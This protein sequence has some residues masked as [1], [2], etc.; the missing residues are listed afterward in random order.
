MTFAGA[1]VGP[2]ARFLYDG[3][4][5]EVVELYAVHGSPEALVREARSDSVR[6]IA[7][8][9]LMFSERSR[10]LTVVQL[11]LERCSRAT[12]R[13]RRSPLRPASRGPVTYLISREGFGRRRKRKSSTSDC[14]PLSAG[15]AATRR[16]AKLDY[17][18]T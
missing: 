14:E 6:R 3:E 9:E 10:L 15:S 11:I 12:V 2:G 4:M 17:S 7:M 18:R 8:S 1:R 5:I 13:A 16:P